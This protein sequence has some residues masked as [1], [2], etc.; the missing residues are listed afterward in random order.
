MDAG[1]RIRARWRRLTAGQRVLLAAAAALAAACGWLLTPPAGLPDGPGTDVGSPASIPA[2][3]AAGPAPVVDGLVQ[4]NVFARS[5]RPPAERWVPEEERRP[6]GARTRR[7][8]E[9]EEEAPDPA[10]LAAAYRLFGTVVDGSADGTFAVIEAE[11]A[12][13]GP[14]VYRRGDRIGPFRVGSIG[15]D[16]VVL[17]LGDRRVR[18]WLDPD[19]RGGASG[20]DAGR[21]SR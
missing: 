18:L 16:R 20:G 10:A 15:R 21:G 7:R 8:A 11:P 6:T 3:G 17:A 5:R 4:G 13:P 2:V 12:T 9:A 1:R 19:R 14:E